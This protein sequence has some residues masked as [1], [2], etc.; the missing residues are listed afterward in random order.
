MFA[1]LARRRDRVFAASARMRASRLVRNFATTRSESSGRAR[2]AAVRA[3]STTSRSC[4][5]PLVSSASSVSRIAS[6]RFFALASFGFA[7]AIFPAASTARARTASGVF[8]SARD[9][10]I[11]SAALADS[12]SPR[13]N[14]A[15]SR[16]FTDPFS[17]IGAS[18]GIAFSSPIRPAA[19]I[20]RI[21]TRSS[22]WLIR[23][24]RVLS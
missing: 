5:P 11:A 23:S 6:P 18:C 4:L 10:I 1:F 20:A 8:G 14:A 15:I 2:K 17:S 13:A 7:A 19:K 9:F 22:A 16:T 21:L 12:I 3:R 24:S